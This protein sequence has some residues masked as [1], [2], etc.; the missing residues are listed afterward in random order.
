MFNNQKARKLLALGIVTLIMFTGITSASN[1]SLNT[2]ERIE[3]G[4]GVILTTTCDTYLSAKLTSEFDGSDAK[5]YVQDLILSDI[6]IRLHGKRVSLALRNDGADEVLT[7]NQLYFDL[8]DNGIVFTSPLSHT[9][10]IDYTTRSQFGAN[11]IGASSI[12]FTNIRKANGSKIL[13]D[14]VSRVVV[15]TSKGGGCTEPTISCATV[16]SVCSGTFSSFSTVSGATGQWEDSCFAENEQIFY[17]TDVT[18]GLYKSSTIPGYGSN[19][20]SVSVS[21]V[22]ASDLP[23]GTNY[24]ALGCS[25]DGKYLIVGGTNSELKYSNDFGATWTSKAKTSFEPNNFTI[26]E[27]A[28]SDD[29]SVVV[30]ATARRAFIWLNGKF[31]TNNT[32]LATW[33]HGENSGSK[34]FGTSA[35]I[36]ASGD[37]IWIGGESNTAGLYLWTASQLTDVVDNRGSLPLYNGIRQIKARWTSS[38]ANANF[39]GSGIR[40]I[41]TSADGNVVAVVTWRIVSDNLDKVFVTQDKFATPAYEPSGTATTNSGKAISPIAVSLSRDGKVL[42]VA[43]GDRSSQSAGTTQTSNN[44]GQSLTTTLYRDRFMQAIAVSPQGRRVVVGG[45][46]LAGSVSLVILGVA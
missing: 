18:K 3:F 11:E 25:Y 28:I 41:A 8:D 38:I 21:K 27:I 42:G 14:E 31:W 22:S 10:V 5:F 19:L 7:S 15:E 26:N 40:Y 46:P 45:F 30:V 24:Y 20:S 13:S 1:I 37:T 35:A 23:S 36:S 33:Y 16:S 12:T 34:T 39:T 4:Q 17:A 6:S 44:Y 9:D 32:E 29:G 2:G 43:L